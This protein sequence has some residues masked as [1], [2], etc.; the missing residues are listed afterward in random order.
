MVLIGTGVFA[1]TPVIREVQAA[2]MDLQDPVPVEFARDF[3][4]STAYAPLPA[5]F[6]EQIVAQ[7][8]KLPAR[9]WRQV[10]D[11]VV[12]YDDEGQLARITAPTLLMWGERD[13]LFSREDQD[14]L[15][16]A[17]RGAKLRLYQETGH[18]PNWERPQQVA[19]DLS[20]FIQATY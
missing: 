1:A 9:L 3:Q 11:G 10:L 6:F 16:T 17:I 4:A 14:R 13:A 12:A 18:C 8:M 5:S 15:V 2:L 20:A 19:A 7:S